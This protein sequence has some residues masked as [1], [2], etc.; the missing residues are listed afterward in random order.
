MTCIKYCNR[1]LIGARALF[2]ATTH[3]EGV[4]WRVPQRTLLSRNYNNMVW[5]KKHEEKLM[6]VKGDNSTCDMVKMK[7][8]ISKQQLAQ[9][10]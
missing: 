9:C 8:T 2:D 1:E 5:M 6:V 3:S 7:L 4:H 10:S